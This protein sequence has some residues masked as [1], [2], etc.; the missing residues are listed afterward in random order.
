MLSAVTKEE[1]QMVFE[2]EECNHCITRCIYR[3]T[4]N[5]T[6]ERGFLYTCHTQGKNAGWSRLPVAPNLQEDLFFTRLNRA[7]QCKNQEPKYYDPEISDDFRT[8]KV[9]FNEKKGLTHENDMERNC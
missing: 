6:I 3:E 1:I 8:E 9:K 5:L 7:K 4:S 2:Y